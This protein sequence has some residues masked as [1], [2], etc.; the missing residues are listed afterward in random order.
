MAGSLLLGL[1]A[2]LSWG[3]HDVCVRFISQRAAILPTLLSVLIAGGII[4]APVTIAAGDWQDMTGLAYTLAA[5]TGISFAFASYSLYRAFTIGPVRLVSPLIA[6]YPVL[7]VG[8][9]SISGA[10]VSAGQWAAVMTIIA[11]VALVANNGERAEASDDGNASRRAAIIWSLLAGA[12]FAFTFSTG[13]TA[14]HIGA[15]LPVILIT[16]LVAIATIGLALVFR[17]GIS[18]RTLADT[19]HPLLL[20]AMGGLDALALGAVTISGT[21]P[22]PEYAAVTSSVFGMVTVVLAWLFLKE[23]MTPPQWGGVIIIFAAIAY[24]GL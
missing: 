15:E 7:S 9:A 16:R 20:C 5:I 6:S 14:A 19:G 13:Q 4:A 2:A 18:R 1:L 21:M 22:H 17:H 3:I 8:W 23:K 24:L 12:G 11:G 10:S